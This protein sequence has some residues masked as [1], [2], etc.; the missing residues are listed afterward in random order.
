M[1]ANAFTRDL[2]SDNTMPSLFS[3]HPLWS[4]SFILNTLVALFALVTDVYLLSAHWAGFSSDRTEF[5]AFW[6]A[7]GPPLATNFLIG[8]FFWGGLPLR[9]WFL[10]GW[11]TLLFDSAL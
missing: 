6:M 8:D 5:L 9:F 4:I 10:Q 1:K 3:E 2:G 7:G 11:V